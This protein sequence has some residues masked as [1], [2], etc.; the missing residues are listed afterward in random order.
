MGAPAGRMS[1]QS[2]S[3]GE[4]VRK[5]VGGTSSLRAHTPPSPPPTPIVKK[6][7][8]QL[9]IPLTLDIVSQQQN[10]LSRKLITA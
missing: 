7:K 9:K 1:A 5:C 6:N 2:G 10:L 3:K 8:P 4:V